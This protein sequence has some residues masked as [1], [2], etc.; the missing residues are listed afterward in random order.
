M[1]LMPKGK[2]MNPDWPVLEINEPVVIVHRDPN[3]GKLNTVL[4]DFKDHSHKAYGLIC[5][6]IIGHVAQHYGV[7]TSDVLEWVHKELDNP[8]TDLTRIGPN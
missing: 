2:K 1:P 6:D 3:D 5:A 8:T 7:E 4:F